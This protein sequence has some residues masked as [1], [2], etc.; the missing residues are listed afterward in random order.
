MTASSARTRLWVVR[1]TESGDGSGGEVF[2]GDCVGCSSNV[3]SAAWGGVL[4]RV[5]W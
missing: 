2:A 4:L 1:C 3:G 5:L